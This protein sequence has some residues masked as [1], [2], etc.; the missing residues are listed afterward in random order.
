MTD[1]YGPGRH[2]DDDLLLDLALSDVEEPLRDNLTRHIALCEPCRAEYAAIADAVDH[3]LAATPRVAPPPGFSRSVLAAM[4]IGAMGMGT[5]SELPRAANAQRPGAATP[6]RAATRSPRRFALAAAAAVALVLAG[7]GGAVVLDAVTDQPAEVA[8]SGPALLTG[9]GDRVGTILRSRHYDEPVFV[10]TLTAG[11]PGMWYECVLVSAD[12]SRQSGGSWVVEDGA[13]DTWIV[14][15]PAGAD[16]AG[17]A[18]V[19]MELVTEDGRT[20]ASATL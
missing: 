7:A 11:R 12:G 18:V 6:Q 3:V 8:A 10:V 9:E 16:V 13:G 2:P 19:G 14:A 20:W 4:G 17:A 1:Q 5:V 15:A